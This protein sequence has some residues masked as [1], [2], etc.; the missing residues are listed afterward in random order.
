MDYT[1]ARSAHTFRLGLLR[2]TLSTVLVVL[3]LLHA[4]AL[5]LIPELHVV[6]QASVDLRDAD[7]VRVVRLHGRA[8]QPLAEV[9]GSRAHRRRVVRRLEDGA[10]ELRE[11]LEFRLQTRHGGWKRRPGMA[12]EALGS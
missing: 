9:L 7:A 11:L 6:G 1:S 2:C 8:L 5:L 12:S 10:A 3:H 4:V